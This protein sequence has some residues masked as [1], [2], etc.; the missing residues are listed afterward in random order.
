MN[1]WPGQVQADGT[2]RVGRFWLPM[3]TRVVH[4]PPAGAAVL[5]GIRPEQ[6]AI[7]PDGPLELAADWTEPLLSDNATLVRGAL[8]D[9]PAIVQVAGVTG[10]VRIGDRIRV[11][12]DSAEAHLF[13]ADTGE[14]LR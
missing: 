8:G 9:I 3:P 11:A 2:V 10:D 14:R 6:M 4:P 13:D 1:I 7:D 5:Y 12:F